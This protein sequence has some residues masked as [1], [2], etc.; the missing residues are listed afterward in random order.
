MLSA[1]LF[2]IETEGQVENIVRNCISVECSCARPI[3]EIPEN[4]HTDHNVHVAD[5]V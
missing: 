1:S 5:I 3:L 2:T 4:M